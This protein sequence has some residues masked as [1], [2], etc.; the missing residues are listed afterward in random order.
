MKSRVEFKIEINIFKNGEETPELKPIGDEY[1]V[2][3]IMTW[4]MSEGLT[5]SLFEGLQAVVAHSAFTLRA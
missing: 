4:P 5:P 2:A 1:K 3:G